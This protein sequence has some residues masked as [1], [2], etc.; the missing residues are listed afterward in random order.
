M[1]RD[2]IHGMYEPKMNPVDLNRVLSHIKGLTSVN[3]QFELIANP[4]PLPLILSDHGLLKCIFGN[5][6][7][8]AL[9]YGKPGGK[10]TTRATFHPDTGIFEMKVVNLPGPGHQQ[11]VDLGERAG[12]L[13]FSHGTRL[14]K[15]TSQAKESLSAGDGAWIIRKC[16]AILCGTVDIS[17]EDDQTVFSFEAPVKL[18]DESLEANAFAIPQGVWG[19]AIDDSKIQRKLL[20]RFFVHAGIHEHHQIILGQNPE[21]IL[22][23]VDFAVNFVKR[24]PNDRCECLLF[25]LTTTA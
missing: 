15:D 18:Y 10:I 9:K 12:E 16:A 6:I 3:P 4:S 2:V 8:N 23:F 21:E 5:A 25:I 19:I 14:H 20:R 17:F 7:R 11:L 13:V 1:A 22:N 24:H